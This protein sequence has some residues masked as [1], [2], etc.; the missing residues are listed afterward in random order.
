MSLAMLIKKGGLSSL[1]TATAAT[2]AT[3]KRETMAT[4]APVATVAVADP[5]EPPHDL[6]VEEEA[7]IHAWLAYIGETSQATIDEMVSQ[8]RNNMQTRRYLLK[9]SEEVPGH[10]VFPTLVA[11]RGCIHFQ[12]IDHP[13]L[14]HCSQGQPE[15]VAGNWDDD[16]RWCE[17]FSPYIKN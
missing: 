15:A 7:S 13:H 4:V 2:L 8:C 5:Q 16:C 12:R 17:E 6:S 1:A 9:R 14:G 11:C 3:D 10:F